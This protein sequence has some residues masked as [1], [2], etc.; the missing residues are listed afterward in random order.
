MLP[1]ADEPLLHLYAEGESEEASNR[2][3]AQIREVVEEILSAEGAAVR[4]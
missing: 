2:L 1:D 3:E 4:T